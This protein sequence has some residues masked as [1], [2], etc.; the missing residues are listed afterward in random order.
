M[1]SF[2]TEHVRQRGSKRCG[3]L[4]TDRL[5]NVYI[6][7]GKPGVVPCVAAHLDTVHEPGPVKIVRKAGRLFGVDDTGEHT[8]IGADDKAGVFICLELLERF[9]D[10]MVVLF[11]AEEIGCIGAQQ[12]PAEWFKDAGY[13]IEFDCPGRGLVSYTSN[14]VRLF[15][16][17]GEFMAAAAPV[18]KAHGLT[19]WQHHPFTDVMS[20]RRRFGF[21]CLNLSSGY[22]NWHRQDEYLVLDEVADALLAGEALI[23]AL[24]C[25]AYPFK[26]GAEPDGPPLFEITGLQVNPPGSISAVVGQSGGVKRSPSAGKTSPLCPASAPGGSSQFG[27]GAPQAAF[28]DKIC[29]LRHFSPAILLH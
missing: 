1:V 11:A 26:P 12:A 23:T 8:G 4:V 16:N 7:K 13:V 20:L 24:G 9:D 3:Q 15:A 19:R 17:G 5:N 25:R 29:C 22:Y 2:L 18:L 28:R 27:I 10:I 14:G 6:R 21:S